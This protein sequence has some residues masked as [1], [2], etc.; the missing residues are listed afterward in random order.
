[1]YHIPFVLSHI[2]L[3]TTTV[4]LP[5]VF[6]NKTVT[7]TFNRQ[8]DVKSNEALGIWHDGNFA[9]KIYTTT[10][11]LGKLSDDYNRAG[12]AGLP[13]GS[14]KFIQGSVKQGTDKSTEGFALVTRWLSGTEFNFHKPPKPFKT[15]LR[16]QNISHRK[17][18]QD[19]KRQ[20]SIDIHLLFSSQLIIYLSS[21]ILGGCTSENI[22]GLQDA[23]GF[24]QAG[25][26]EPIAFF[27]IHTSW[28]SQ[29]K[30]F[31]HSEQ[32]QSLMDDITNWGT[33]P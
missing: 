17:S 3:V 32:A 22:V 2:S 16:T 9:W 31:G 27:D 28:N 20:V 13:M 18:S 23:Q 6:S 26:F 21:R 10:V 30:H 24:V 8:P 11:Q 7:R 4:K 14:P 33:S 29:T 15:A 19:Y 12:V 5:V 25:V 1:M